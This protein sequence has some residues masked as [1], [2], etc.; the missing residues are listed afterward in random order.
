MDSKLVIISILEE[1]LNRAY[2]S[3]F[4]EWRAPVPTPTSTPFHVHVQPDRQSEAK[5]TF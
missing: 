5:D 3:V 2:M 1:C 4:Q